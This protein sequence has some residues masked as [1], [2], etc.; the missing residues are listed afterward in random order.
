MGLFGSVAGNLLGTLYFLLYQC[1][2]F[3]IAHRI[4]DE[5]ENSG[6]K[7]L[8]G[9]VFGSFLL[10]WCPTVLSLL[11]Q[12]TVASHIAALAF[13]IV[14][15]GIVW[16]F[17]EKR[18][19]SLN[20]AFIKEDRVFLYLL[21]PTFIYFVYVLHT[22]TL[23]LRDGAL[24]AGQCSYGDMNMHLGFVSSIAVQHTFPPEYSILPGTK[25]G[26]PFLSDSISSSI[27]LFGASLRW[28]YILPMLFAILQVFVGFYCFAKA[29]LKEK[30]KAVIA[31]LLLFFNGG[32]GFLYFV[33]KSFN[34]GQTFT[35]IFTD[36]YQTPTN[37]NEN[38]IRWSNTIV[39]MLLP[40]RATLFG[41]AM[42][43][44][45]L[46]LLYR[47]VFD[48][49]KR[50]FIPAAVIAGGLPMIHTHSFMVLG[51]I[52]AAW[53]LYKLYT[54][55]KKEKADTTVVGKY[56][57]VIGLVFMVL[58]QLLCKNQGDK[59]SM[60]LIITLCLVLGAMV[61]YGIYLLYG[62]IKAG[63]LKELLS[64]WGIFLGIILIMALPQLLTWTFQQVN[65]ESFLK[66]HFNWVNEMDNYLWFYVK[67]IGLTALFAV[68]AIMYSKKKDF[69]VV[70]PALII[71]FVA[72]M[73][74]F[75]PNSYDNNKLLYGAFAL[76]CCITAGYV[77]DLYRKMQ[78]VPGRRYYAAIFLFLCVFSAVLTMGREAVSEYELYSSNQVQVAQYVEQH[79]EPDA[80]ILTN[81]RHN[82]AISSL[83]GRNIVCGTGTFLYYHG[84]NYSSREADVKQMYENPA[85]TQ[86]L[87][88][89]YNVGYVL[90]GPE[91][92]S[93]FQVDEGA[94][95]A[96]Y[97]PVYTVADVTLY[98]VQ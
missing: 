49:K 72:E 18:K 24:F 16:K 12:F 10:H 6:I 56:I 27:Y 50:Y 82:N 21:V 64:T 28:S 77:V 8:L 90:V 80:V 65:G 59:V 94:I 79:L 74:V 5:E 2:G 33:D 73:M 93:S 89:K 92:R 42:L 45:C 70:F 87:Y 25:L 30:A 14:I 40:Q 3:F 11:M 38:N 35:R 31:W 1:I 98:K 53:L 75:Q 96:A 52:S 57:V 84:V 22:H 46:F 44:T 68:P 54:P 95:K 39:D 69:A 86:D 34:N 4:L 60:P 66:G 19:L 29:W 78:E 63:K 17:T 67:N 41:W 37:L 85:G 51:I 20:T 88:E 36:F 43:F 32:F 62:Q 76:I 13:A 61:V 91:E 15:A 47:A 83:T 9:S 48:G 97:Q 81:Q 7:L 23:L 26:Y 55:S 58:L 71:W